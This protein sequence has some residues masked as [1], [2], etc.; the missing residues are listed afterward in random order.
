MA[1]IL[2]GRACDLGLAITVFWIIRRFVSVMRWQNGAALR[3]ESI[4]VIDTAHS[5]SESWFLIGPERDVP[6][7][8]GDEFFWGTVGLPMVY[9]S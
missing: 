9:F 8:E 1:I 7:A 5:C 6:I 2:R 4:V 3:Y